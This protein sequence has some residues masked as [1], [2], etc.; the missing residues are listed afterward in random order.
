MTTFPKRVLAGFLSLALVASFVPTSILPKVAFAENSLAVNYDNS[1]LDEALAR[2]SSISDNGLIPNP[3]VKTITEENGITTYAAG[4]AP[5]SYD[6][7]SSDSK[8][9]VTEVKNQNPWGDCWSFGSNG[10]AEVSIASALGKT[11]NDIDLSERHTA[12]FLNTPLSSSTDLLPES[13]KSQAGEGQ[14]Y[15]NGGNR[16][17]NTGG[18]STQA[19]QLFASGIGATAESVAP[20]GNNGKTMS[21]SDTW[22]VSESS[23]FSSVAR[24]KNYNNLGST[25]EWNDYSNHTGYSLSL[26]VLNRVK[27]EIISGRAV[28]LSYKADQ[29]QPGA[30][31]DSTYMNRTTWG[32]FNPNFSEPDHSVLI[33]GYDDNFSK[34]SFNTAPEGDGAFIVKN[35]W[36][37]SETGSSLSYGDVNYGTYGL[38]N[39]GYFYLSYYDRTINSLTSFE[40]DDNSYS[41]SPYGVDDK[42]ID[43][44]DFMPMMSA[45]NSYIQSD[46]YKSGSIFTATANQTLNSVTT[47][48]HQDNI[49]VQADVYKLNASATNPAD[50]EKVATSSQSFPYAGIHS[51]PLTALTGKD[52]NINK[53]DKYGVV[54][55][56]KD[57]DGAYYVTYLMN[58]DR[59]L[60]GSTYGNAVVNDGESYLSNYDRSTGAF[61]WQN[62]NMQNLGISSYSGQFV[63]DNP[64]IKV[65]STKVTSSSTKHNV[66]FKDGSSSLTIS[67][68]PT[69]FEEGSNITLP[70]APAKAGYT[71]EGWY[72]DSAF[73]NKAGD[74]GATYSPAE[75]ADITL[76]AKYSLKTTKITWD[77]QS[78]SSATISAL[79]GTAN[80]I[81]T[82]SQACSV[83]NSGKFVAPTR[84]GY[85]FKG[86]YDAA[87]NGK[88]YINADLTSAAN[89][90]KE[91]ETATLYAQWEGVTYNL[92]YMVDGTE[93]ATITPKSYV[94]GSNGGTVTLT[95]PTKVGYT[96][97]GWYTTSTFQDGTKLQQNGT[98]FNTTA[99]GDR[100]LYGRF[101]GKETALTFNMA[102][103][104]ATTAPGSVKAT[105]GSAMPALSAGNIPTK[106]DNRFDGFFDAENGGTK[107][108]NADGTSAKMWDKDV[109]TATLYAHWV[110]TAAPTHSVTFK[111]GNDT[112][113]IDGAPT[114]FTEGGSI[115][116]PA[117]PEKTG[118][119]FV[120]WCTDEALTTVAGGA[121]A[122]YSPT[123]TAD[124]TLYA[125]YEAKTYS[126]TYKF[127]SSAADVSEDRTYGVAYNL[128]RPTDAQ[129]PS[130]TATFEGWY[131]TYDATTGAYSDKVDSIA[132]TDE[133]VYTLYARWTYA[134]IEGQQV[135]I[136]IKASDDVV[137]RVDFPLSRLI[138][139]TING[140]DIKSL[141]EGVDYT[142]VEG[143]TLLTIKNSYVV[144]NL[145]VGNNEV[146]FTYDNGVATADVEVV[147]ED[148]PVN[149]PAPDPDNPNPTPTPDPD[150]PSSDI[151]EPSNGGSTDE[152][153]INPVQPSK[154]AQVAKT[155]DEANGIVFGLLT[156][157]VVGAVVL[158]IS[159]RRKSAVK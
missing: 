69:S 91:S 148:Q 80:S 124:L 137:I 53:G 142:L 82:Y 149:P 126:V 28:E 2:A 29:A 155:G 31:A 139:I 1:A 85:T 48:T 71:F 14:V 150:Q 112:L 17:M 74:A 45:G 111:D 88:K 25:A 3:K 121:G 104:T 114:E 12:W 146:V 18:N 64:M 89:W 94:Y 125:N 154:K 145:N 118:Y 30:S 4:S 157:L 103:G 23:R 27:S 106:A 86:F 46:E 83:L 26:A 105:F 151:T 120:G 62:W 60:G 101:I 50:G 128:L 99:T 54:I 116:L 68:A 76:Y 16:R 65:Y 44:Y 100:S 132:T 156:L 37:H 22:E 32:Q 36:G 122:Q 67:G 51:V 90:D 47:Y 41:E 98:S 115:E 79:N 96:F 140:V 110:S 127:N 5:G 123:A 97:D 19:A 87:T 8:N 119:T 107:Y 144:N 93:D 9:L 138:S 117:G 73:A 24:L 143:S 133:T 11:T 20:Y 6:L 38:N 10:A 43:Q 159:S 102:G 15:V 55:S 147:E 95:T 134:F 49:T 113:T 7:R 42:I 33:V 34:D 39:S 129:K 72:K 92:K 35:S 152:L 141:V 77:L 40:F 59:A 109:A 84:T 63:L 81:L 108:Y 135:S 136:S 158:T 61:V 78:G 70:T 13:F 21:A 56:L 58:Y 130:T 57:T 153:V 66:T 131:K 52:L 75:T